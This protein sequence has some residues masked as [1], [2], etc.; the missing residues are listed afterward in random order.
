METLLE[1][2]HKAGLRFLEPLSTKET[3]ARIV[4]E[5]QR[6]IKGGHGSIF[7]EKDGVLKR[8]YAS[9]PMLYD[10]NVRKNGFTYQAFRT[11][12]TVVVTRTKVAKINPTS[13][14]MGFKS[15]VF[16]PLLYRTRFTGVLSINLLRDASLSKNELRVLMV[17]G[18][19]ATF[20]IRKAQMHEQ[21]TKALEVRDL[22]IS[23]AAHELR[24]PLTTISGYAQL[25]YGKLVR[26]K[27]PQARWSEQ[28]HWETLRLKYLIDELLEINRIKTGQ[29][30]YAWKECHIRDILNRALNNFGFLHPQSTIILEDKL[31]KQ[32]DKAD[33]VIGDFDKLLQMLINIMDNAGKFSPTG[34]PVTVVLDSRGKNLCIMVKDKGKGIAEETFTEAIEGHS[35]GKP[36]KEGMGF[37]L[38]LSKHIALQHH[39]NISFT[40]SKTET[41]VDIT[42]PK[43]KL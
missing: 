20:A 14:K 16:I 1:K 41:T 42:I 29:L 3:Y 9:S 5:A 38:F 37:G 36:G 21:M 35:I 12:K 17:F 2:V 33:V 25:L 11:K 13:K 39:G 22:F 15:S 6:L 4:Q 40:P 10:I 28:L 19:M 18:S 27:T 7:L 24:T 23:M 30:Q 26:Q 8:V 32:S 43:A 34:M 31:P